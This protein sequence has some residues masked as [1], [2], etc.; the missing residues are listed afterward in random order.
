MAWLGAVFLI[1]W[2]GAVIFA[3]VSFEQVSDAAR[4]ARNGAVIR[5]DVLGMPL[6]EGFHDPGRSGVRVGWGLFVIL[7]APAVIGTLLAFFGG[8]R[9]A[10]GK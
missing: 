8:A 10:S 1:L 9:N 6:F 5:A 2:V 7:V 3:G 4:M